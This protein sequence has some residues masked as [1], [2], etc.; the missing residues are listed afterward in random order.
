MNE[1]QI[2]AKAL[3]T[4]EGIAITSLDTKGL[5][6]R[7]NKALATRIEE[8]NIINEKL[9]LSQKETAKQLEIVRNFQ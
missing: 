2:V 8:L 1:L 9:S 7:I 4:Y 5:G 3:Q 6:E